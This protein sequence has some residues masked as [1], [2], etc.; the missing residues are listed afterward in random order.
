M[1]F[2]DHG[3]Y[4]KQWT[5][6]SNISE[7][8]AWT[9]LRGYLGGDPIVIA[10]ESSNL[11]VLTLS[12][13]DGALW[14]KYYDGETW[15]PSAG[16]WESLRGHYVSSFAAVSSDPARIDTFGRGRDSAIYHGSLRDNFRNNTFENLGGPFAGQPAAAAWGPDRLDVFARGTDGAI[17]WKAWNGAVWQSKWTSLGGSFVSAPTAV[18]KEIGHLSVFGIN[19]DGELLTKYFENGAWSTAWG[20]LGGNLSSTIAVQTTSVFGTKRYD[21][22]AVDKEQ[23]LSQ[24]IWTGSSWLPWVKHFGPV[25]SAPTV[26]STGCDRLDLFV[27]NPDHNLTHHAW[28]GDQ[29]SP[30]ISEGENVGGEFLGF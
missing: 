5:N 9:D 11:S 1:G 22:F 20:N 21:I 24:K 10:H 17:W 12:G 2:G 26:T 23:V 8:T 29:W 19:E 14:Y 18:S 27:L 7:G 16:S 15:Y 28:S 6:P 3:L 4:H 13:S 30:S 25:I